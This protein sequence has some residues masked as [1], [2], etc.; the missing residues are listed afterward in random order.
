MKRL[1]YFFFSLLDWVSYL[2]W[3]LLIYIEYL[4]Y[5]ER[6]SMNTWASYNEFC[7]EKKAATFV[8]DSYS[9]NIHDLYS[10]V[11]VINCKLELQ[12]LQKSQKFQQTKNWR[13]EKGFWLT[14]F[15]RCSRMWPPYGEPN[16]LAT[17]EQGWQFAFASSWRCKWPSWYDWRVCCSTIPIRIDFNL[18]SLI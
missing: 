8:R 2:D 5:R 4:I 17:K 11:I 15:V 16:L 7:F 3:Y 13:I 12:K 1:N 9:T 10:G 6:E 18:A 14:F